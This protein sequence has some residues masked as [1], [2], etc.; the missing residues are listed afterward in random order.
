MTLL[1]R[2]LSFG[3]VKKWDKDPETQDPSKFKSGTQD[4]LKIK[5]GTPGPLSKF[6]SGTAI[7]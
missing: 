2:A 6:K 1:K 5:S 7:L 4:P 3:M